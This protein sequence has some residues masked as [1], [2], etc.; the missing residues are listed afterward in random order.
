MAKYVKTGDSV[1]CV[2]FGNVD[3]MEWVKPIDAAKIRYVANRLTGEDVKT[4]GKDVKEAI[5]WAVK[6]TKE[7]RGML[8]GTGS[9]Y[10]V[11]EIH[12]LLRDDSE[13]K[14]EE[15]EDE[16]DDML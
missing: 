10:L 8:V 9:L 4:F 12:R 15:D 13:F 14:N 2:E 1:A 7:R 6:Q 5:K 11:G 16:D 3:G